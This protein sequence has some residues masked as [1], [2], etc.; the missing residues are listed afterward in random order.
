[1]FKKAMEKLEEF[2]RF[3]YDVNSSKIRVNEPDEKTQE[4]MCEKYAQERRLTIRSQ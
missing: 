3:R 4:D 2:V 1:M